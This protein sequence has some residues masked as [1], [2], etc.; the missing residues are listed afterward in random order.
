MPD[1]NDSVAGNRVVTVGINEQLKI[2]G[3]RSVTVGRNEVINVTGSST[4]TAQSLRLQALDQLELVCGAAS[5]LL[6]K[7]G[8]VVIKGK[9][10]TIEGSGKVNVK[11]A[12]DVVIKGS[13]VT[14]N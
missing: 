4:T 10:I 14:Q 13:K 5:V 1:S 3:E 6:K 11:A 7:D 12:G 8:T 2:A 9:D